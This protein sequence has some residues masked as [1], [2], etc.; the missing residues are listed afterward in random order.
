EGGGHLVGDVS[1][2]RDASRVAVCCVQ[3]V[4]F[5]HHQGHAAPQQMLRDGP[6]FP[7]LLPTGPGDL[8]ANAMSFARFTPAVE[9][10]RV[11]DVA[12]QRKLFE[13]SRQRGQFA[14]WSP[15]LSPDGRHLLLLSEPPHGWTVYDLD[16][17]AAKCTGDLLASVSRPLGNGFVRFAGN[18]MM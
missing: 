4:R 17:G 11:W 12:R 1:M 10:I 5:P 16:S 6:L 3:D 15:K 2:S 14:P 8:I 9:R 13:R 7:A 18:R